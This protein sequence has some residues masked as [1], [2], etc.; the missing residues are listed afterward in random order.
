[1]LLNK[2]WFRKYARL[3]TTVAVVGLVAWETD[4]QQVG[5]AFARLRL[6]LWLAAVGVLITTQFV[7]AWR[8][9]ALARPLGFERTIKQMVSYYFIGM[10]F[11][12]L[13][14]TSVGG[15]VVRAWYL[16]GGAGRR[17]AAFAAVFLDRFSGLVVLL[18]LACLGVL[19]TPLELPAWIV[20][21]VWSTA[22]CAALIVAGVPWVA[23]LQKRA[24][25]LLR[26]M[27]L[28]LKALRS[29]RLIVGSTILSFVVQAGNI[30]LVWLIGM[31]IGAD[32]P[33]GYYWIMVPMVSLLAMLPVSI[34]GMGVREGATA[35][36]LAHLGVP[37]GTAKTLAFLWF[38]VFLT[39]SL[40]GGVVYLF[41]HFPRPVSATATLNMTE[42]E[43]G[44][45]DCG[46]D[47]GRARQHQAVTWTGT[48]KH[49]STESPL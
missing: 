2:R 28:A 18:S 20:W 7:S 3:V 24:T 30:V 46:A 22:G 33:G 19:L 48:A 27:Q 14:P 35:L 11:N 16:D 40:L 31:A 4:W 21:F 6:E 15:D 44:S 5:A 12:L 36:F 37:D 23:K 10:Y 26:K 47:Q 25:G 39:V 45:I 42:V 9:Q 29:P 41:G 43:D 38:A 49:R 8:W 32:V 13:L 1:L 17:L 34:N